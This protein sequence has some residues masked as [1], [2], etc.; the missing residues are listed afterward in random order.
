MVV[1]PPPR[2]PS[3]AIPLRAIAGAK[4][5]FD[6]AAIF[7]ILAFQKIPHKKFPRYI[8]LGKGRVKEFF[9]KP[10]KHDFAIG[11]LVTCTC[12]G[13]LAVIIELYDTNEDVKM[14]MAKIWWIIFPHAGIKER[15]WMHTI[16]ELK[17]ARELN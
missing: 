16:D 12:H 7:E 2:N 9:K 14:N 6:I 8:H 11:D 4:P 15:D 13:G 1:P 10:P 17:K 3:L 5:V